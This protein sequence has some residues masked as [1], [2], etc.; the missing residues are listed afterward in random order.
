MK[1]AMTR[2]ITNGRR[3]HQE[4]KKNQSVIDELNSSEDMGESAVVSLMA[5]QKTESGGGVVL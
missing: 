4:L 2:S 3:S 1:A 5:N